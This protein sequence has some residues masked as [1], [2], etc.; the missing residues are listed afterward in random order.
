MAAIPNGSTFYNFSNGFI[1]EY[2]GSCSSW[3]LIIGENFWHPAVRCI[4]YIAAMIYL[5]VGVAIMS[6]VFMGAI[7]VITSKKKTVITYD[8]ETGEQA[9]KEVLIWNETV[10]NLSL[11]ALGSS[12]PEILLSIVETVSEISDPNSVA[13]GLGS[14][15]I[16]GS[17][18]FNLL[19]ITAVCIV[20]VPAP[21]YKRVKEFGVFIITAIWSVFAYVWMLIVTTV[22]TP[23]KIDIFEAWITLAF[24]PLLIL[25]AWAQDNGWWWKRHSQ[26]LPN[27]DKS[28]TVRVVGGKS[29]H[30]S[31]SIIRSTSRE[32]SN[33]HRESVAS[34]HNS[35][36][37]L[38]SVTKLNPGENRSRANSARTSISRSS[39]VYEDHGKIQVDIKP[40]NSFARA[41]FRH[42]AIRSL[43]GGKRHRRSKSV[44]DK[45]VEL[46]SGLSNSSEPKM[47]HFV[48]MITHRLN[49]Q[50]NA[51]SR[52]I[53]ATF[54]FEI[55][56]YSVRED[57]GS[58]DLIV[59]LNRHRA[60]IKKSQE[61]NNKTVTFG[62]G[63][64]TSETIIKSLSSSF[65]TDKSIKSCDPITEESIQDLESSRYSDEEGDDAT[66]N[67][68]SVDFETRDGGAKQGVN[69]KYSAGRLNFTKSEYQKTIT[70]DIL[71]DGQYH[72]NLSFYVI[73]KNPSE[74]SKLAD[75]SVALVTIIDTNVPGEFQFEKAKYHVDK[76]SNQI[77]LKVLRK[78]GV[79]GTVHLEFATID[80]TAHGG[81]I[82]EVEENHKDYESKTDMLI[83]AN[84]ETEK[85][86]V[87]N[88]ASHVKLDKNFLVA[89]RNASMG[90]R[91]GEI[92]ATIVSFDIERD[93]LGDRVA[94]FAALNGVE[95][96]DVSWAEQFTNALT[97][98]SDIDEFGEESP[99]SNLDYIL[100]FIAFL[101][102]IIAATIPP[103]TMLGGWPAFVLSLVYIGFL[104]AIIEQ[105]G[106][107]LGC[108]I[109]LKPSVTGITI[110]ALGTSLPDTFAS[111]NA[112]VHDHSA[113]ASIG[114][115]T[116]SNSVNVFLGLGL[117][118]V[119]VTTYRQIMFSNSDYAISP[120][121]MQFSVILFTVVAGAGVAILLFRRFVLGGE[122]GGDIKWQYITA[123]TLVLLWAVYITLASLRAYDVIRF[124]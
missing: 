21:H 10:A 94:E 48:N 20:S 102:K 92:G 3:L 31:A 1:V 109:L 38:E 30:P 115:V 66:Q 116:G 12:A 9:T 90:A 82:P 120:G 35:T 75:P 61:K 121:D 67:N 52:N 15:T 34:A 99:P 72:P 33:V 98:G 49:E 108:V 76:D 55:A 45:M 32:L 37:D 4:L 81:I 89:L 86:I 114:N 71:N 64:S 8:R 13:D 39:F 59:L 80:G 47:A 107:L 7:E 79:D 60:L 51:S 44:T 42:A 65:K 36:Y 46:E 63:K 113:D 93:A 22:W 74:Y 27:E 18:S 73:L 105:F 14:F 104:T 88:V 117:P 19:I 5:F 97:V 28:L 16:I 26:I 84:G 77:S 112:A 11:M 124:Q 91:I 6:D 17:A 78:K 29:R 118:W 50:S 83:F 53:A 106:N 122:L 85:E 123:A 87:I 25:T 111:R 40:S 70:V 24:F 23:N 96:E 69:F 110:V 56:A 54:V 2:D 41:R 119:L 68:F 62:L 100:H 57:S 103:R 58:I 43:M 95:G 101:W